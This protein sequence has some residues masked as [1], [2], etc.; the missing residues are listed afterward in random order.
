MPG[1]PKDAVAAVL[2]AGGAS[3][4]FDHELSK[5]Y[6]PLRGR[7]LLAYSL[8]TLERSDVV[9]HIVLV[10]RAGDRVATDAVLREVAP[11]KLRA[12]VEGGATRHESETAGLDAVESL[13]DTDWV[14]LHDAARPFVTLDLLDRLV[15]TA[16]GRDTG[17]V[18]GRPFEQAVVDEEGRVVDTSSLIT[19]QTPQLF[20][21][22]DA[23]QAYR[24]AADDDFRGVDTAE[25]VGAYR[26]TPIE[27]VTGDP[28]NFK[29]TTVE[30]L[31]EAERI[32]GAWRGG[33]WATAAEGHATD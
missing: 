21:V 4:R 20:A 10:V 22:D 27:Y 15:T 24:A 19:V 28:L 9:D 30:D 26:E 23:V 33:R 3:T 29:I 11:D 1:A 13:P 31:L 14:M 17:V 5:V 7:P 8:E 25:T 2:L 32:V 12:V 16:R 6:V 18:P